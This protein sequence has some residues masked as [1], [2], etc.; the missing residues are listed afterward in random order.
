LSYKMK[1]Y[2]ALDSTNDEAK[3]LLAT[4]GSH[5]GTILLARTQTGGRGRQN[6]PWISPIGNLYMSLIT[7]DVEPAFLSQYA[8][9][10]G[11]V[12]RQAIA[13]H[14]KID[15]RCKWPND[16]LIEDKKVS[17]VLIERSSSTLIVGVGINI[18]YYPENVMFPATCLAEN[19]KEV[20]TPEILGENIANLYGTLRHRWVEKGFE[21]IRLSWLQS[22][23]KL[24]KEINIR[25][26]ASSVVGIF[27]TIDE[28]GALILKTA[29]GFQKFFAGDLI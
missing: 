2:E 16:V 20:P 18:L 8:L 4:V 22:A 7:Q 25:Q 28:S 26:E 15:V 12:I 21:D 3:R 23:W 6:R 13:E 27:E 29:T 19:T 9:L 1:I 14:T 17:G 5:E 11:L 24:N 10:W